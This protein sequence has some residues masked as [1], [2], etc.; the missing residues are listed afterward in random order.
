MSIPVQNI[1]Y[2]LC[3]A[4]DHVQEARRIQTGG[5]TFAGMADMLGHVL[6]GVVAGLLKAGL[7]RSYVEH[8]GAI[9]GIR[10]KLDVSETVQRHLPWTG[11]TYCHF[12]EFS[13]D[14]LH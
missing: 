4:W 11:R 5:E 6:S 10:G 13:P 7:D 9:P 12:D 14:V 8:A 1:Y 3:Y 2:L